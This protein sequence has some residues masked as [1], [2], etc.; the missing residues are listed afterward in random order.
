MLATAIVTLQN[1]KEYFDDLD[2]YYNRIK[3]N[4]F[5]LF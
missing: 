5:R 2:H 1:E 4:I 3:A